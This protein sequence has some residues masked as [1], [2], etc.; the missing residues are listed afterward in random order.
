MSPSPVPTVLSRRAFLASAAAA[1]ACS[2]CPAR[3]FA[4]PPGAPSELLPQVKPRLRLVYCHPNP[5]LQGW[6]YQG[7]DYEAR[8]KQLTASLERACPNVEFLPATVE[9]MEQ[10]RQLLGASETVDGYIVYFLGIPS[11]YLCRV[12]FS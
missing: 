11:A 12:S 9:N 10:A 2:F 3:C 7:F 6:P 8:K 5:S 4:L 1:A